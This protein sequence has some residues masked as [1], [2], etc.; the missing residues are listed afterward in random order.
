MIL[1]FQ[2]VLNGWKNAKSTL[3]HVCE[4][5]VKYNQNDSSLVTKIAQFHRQIRHVS[6][7][8][9]N[10]FHFSKFNLIF[11]KPWIET[12]CH[13]IEKMFGWSANQ[14][15]QNTRIEGQRSYDIIGYAL[16]F[17][18]IIGAAIRPSAFAEKKL[19]YLNNN[20]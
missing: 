18:K 9:K 1:F 3:N 13:I 16:P 14:F 20:H 8:K 10:Y 11:N 7:E 17:N 19:N 2:T 6:I 12:V 5:L 4:I 15:S